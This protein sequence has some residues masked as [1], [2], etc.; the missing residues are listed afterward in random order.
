MSNVS[1]WET[2][3]PN[4]DAAPPDG[5]PEGMAANTVNDTMREMMAAVAR[6]Y[7]DTNGSLVTGGAGNAYTL[8]TNNSNSSLTDLPLVVFV[9]NRAN[10]GAATLNVDGL[11]AKSLRFGGVALAA[12]V[13]QEDV[14]YI[15]IY[16][17]EDDAFDIVGSPT[18]DA[19][20][21]TTGTLPDA[22]LS[23]NVPLKNAP[24]TFTRSGATLG[25][26]AI[27]IAANT[28]NFLMHETDQDEDGGLWVFSLAGGAF[29]LGAVAD[30]YSGSIPASS[31]VLHSTRSGADITSTTI[32]GGAEIELNADDIDINGDA[33]ISG[34]LAVG[35]AATFAASTFSGTVTLSGAAGARV[36]DIVN[37]DASQI[38]AMRTLSN[39]LQIGARASNGSWS[40]PPAFVITRSGDTITQ[41]EVPVAARAGTAA[42]STSSTLEAG[43]IHHRSANTTVPSMN[44]GQWVAVQNTGTSSITLSEGS[45]VTLELGG[46]TTTGNRTLLAKGFAFIYFRANGVG[47]VHGNGVV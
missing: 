47:V 11:G 30:S 23:S 38:W 29:R 44:A 32:R 43:Q 14:A 22:R 18:R 31:M 5:A 39:Q 8:S 27:T 17:A 45:G 42:T 33:D 40:N 20:Q 46:T 15:A 28:P 3:A 41:V 7:Q 37:T 16:N 35:G 10:T 36:F 24:N 26:A 13:L 1:Q 34:T 19:S 12:G 2:S 6:W 9:A 21:I 25:T 4:N